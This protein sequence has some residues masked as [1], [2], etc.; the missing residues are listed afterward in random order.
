M[1]GIAAATKTN[2]EEEKQANDHHSRPD[3]QYCHVFYREWVSG[4]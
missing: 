3:L 4:P 2:S 1:I